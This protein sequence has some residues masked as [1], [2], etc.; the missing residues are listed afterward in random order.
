MKISVNPALLRPSDNPTICCDATKAQ[1]KL[2]WEP[3]IPFKDTLYDTYKTF[4]DRF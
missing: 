3:R 2:G 1:K 4:Q